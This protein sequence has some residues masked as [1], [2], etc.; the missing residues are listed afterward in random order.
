MVPPLACF[1]HAFTIYWGSLLLSALGVC[2]SCWLQNRRHRGFVLG[3]LG[4]SVHEVGDPCVKFSQELMGGLS[5]ETWT[6]SPGTLSFWNPLFLCL[7]P[8][9]FPP[10]IIKISPQYSGCWG[11]E[12]CFPSGVPHYRKAMHSPP[13]PLSL[14]LVFTISLFI[15][16]LCHAQEEVILEKF[17]LAFLIHPNPDL[18][19]PMDVEISPRKT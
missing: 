8:D 4:V 16:V 10:L 3:A 19:A 13:L 9:L 14:T 5:A 12:S 11:R 6:Q 7:F 1:L 2:T 17:L 15:I 18:F